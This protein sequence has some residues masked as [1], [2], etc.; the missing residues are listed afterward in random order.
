M[1]S[2]V[3]RHVVLVMRT[4]LQIRYD[5]VDTMF[6]LGLTI[7]L[8]TEDKAARDDPRYSTVRLIGT[9]LS[10]DAVA[11]LV[12]VALRE[13]GSEFAI[14]FQETDI[15]AVG[16]A[17]AAHGVAWS[18]P[19]ADAIARDK[20]LQR[21]HLAAHGLP[22]PRFVEVG[23]RD[24]DPALIAPLGLPCVV[25]PS[26][27]ASST[28]VELVEDPARIPEVLDGIAALA[29]SGEGNFYDSMP[30]K[31]AL[32]EEYLPGREVTCDGVVVDGRFHLGGVNTK[33]L[34]H[35]PWFEEDL[36]VLPHGDPA[37]E[38][39]I[40]AVM[41]DLARSLDVR[42]ALLNAEFRQGADGG[43]RVVEFST[44]ISGGHVYRHV[45]D[46]HAVDLVELFLL[47]AF[48]EGP[49]ATELAEQRHPGRLATCIKFVYRDGVVEENW[50]GDARYSPSF[51][52][53]YALAKRGETV[54][55][56]PHGFDI[57]GLLSVW[58]PYDPEN[59]PAGIH[60]IADEVLS[61]VHLD[62]RPLDRS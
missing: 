38:A 3:N 18:R 16:L 31:W 17:N 50:A 13:T 52:E 12:A 47:A 37:V 35:P 54:R 40:T 15:V 29:A 57:C 56:A 41:E 20:T 23:D 61:Q 6:R 55:S 2:R 1:T 22:S 51:R 21:A 26:R 45:R 7:H 11:D 9:G 27:G 42:V 5:H 33:Q 60:H 44:R 43:Y 19:E 34:P 28:H 59:H 39:E 32:V 14:T 30:E 62:V 58:G 25:K 49:A 4:G 48:G 8:V 36:Y 46:V 24:V 10:T 53:Y